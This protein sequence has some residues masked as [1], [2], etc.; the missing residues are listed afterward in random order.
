MV[1]KKLGYFCIVFVLPER[2]CFEVVI[3]ILCCVSCHLCNIFCV[4]S[5]VHICVYINTNSESFSIM[6]CTC[7]VRSCTALCCI[8]FAVLWHLWLCSPLVNCHC[9]INWL[10]LYILFLLATLARF[11]IH[12]MISDTLG[13]LIIRFDNGK[14]ARKVFTTLFNGQFSCHLFE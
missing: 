5:G 9:H 8:Q 1:C 12:A 6:S 11:R 10:L 2:K 14:E 7:V 4:S 3:V 13:Y